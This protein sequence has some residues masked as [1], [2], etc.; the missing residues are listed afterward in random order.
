VVTYPNIIKLNAVAQEVVYL[1]NSL[2]RQTSTGHLWLVRD[3]DQKKAMMAQSFARLWD[4][5]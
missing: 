1:L 5:G 4:A 2:A 3:N